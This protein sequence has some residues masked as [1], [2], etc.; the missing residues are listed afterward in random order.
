MAYDGVAE[1]KATVDRVIRIIVDPS[2]SQLGAQQTN[3]ALRSVRRE[4]RATNRE[5][6]RGG[7]RSRDQFRSVGNELRGVSTQVS[8]LRATVPALIG[9]LG[10]R[11][12]LTYADAWRSLTNRLRVV[13]ESTAELVAN[14]Q[15]VVRIALDTRQSVQAITQLYS[16]LTLVST[17]L[18]ASQ[19]EIALFTE[20]V[21]Q[22]LAVQGTGAQEARGALI[23]LSQAIGGTIVRAEEFNSINEAT[24]VL[25]QAVARGME[26]TGGSISALRREI[27]DGNVTS[28]EFFDSFLRGS[29]QIAEQFG[30]TE[31]T[32]SQGVENLGTG[33]TVLV[34]RVDEAVGATRILGSVLSGVGR[35]MGSF[36]DDTGDATDR[37]SEINAELR[38]LSVS[39]PASN[40]F[41]AG[42]APAI[43]FL[44]RRELIREQDIIQR[45]QINARPDRTREF[46]E[47]PGAT[48]REEESGLGLR[49]EQ[50]E[51]DAFRNLEQREKDEERLR[52]EKQR[53]IERQSRESIS[54]RAREARAVE[55]LARDEAVLQIRINN[56]IEEE[57]EERIRAQTARNREALDVGERRSL[58][59]REPDQILADD[60]A[61]LTDE[62]EA[63][64][65]AAEAL[66]EANP[67]TDE[68]LGDSIKARIADFEAFTEREDEFIQINRRLQ[69]S[70]RG[71]SEDFLADFIIAGAQGF[72]DLG[73]AAEQFGRR[74][75]RVL[76]QAI[77]EQ[78][79]LLA[80]Q[81][82]TGTAGTG[83]LINSALGSLQEGGNVAKGTVYN[84]GELGSELFVPHSFTESAAPAARASEVTVQ[85]APTQGEP[86]LLPRG[87]VPFL[88]PE[89]GVIIPN[90]RIA[91]TIER[92]T[93]VD[94]ASRDVVSR[95]TL[96]LHVIPDV[97][98]SLS[99]V[100][101]VEF[102]DIPDDIRRDVRRSVITDVRGVEPGDARRSVVT[103]K[104][105]RT[106]TEETEAH[107]RILSR[108]DT[109]K[110]ERETTDANIQRAETR[111]NDTVDVQDSTATTIREV[112]QGVFENIRQHR[113]ER[114][115]LS[116]RRSEE[117]KS[118]TDN[119]DIRR[120]DTLPVSQN[121]PTLLQVGMR[122]ILSTT[123]RL[124]STSDSTQFTRERIERSHARE[125]RE[126][127]TVTRA[128]DQESKDLVQRSRR[129]DVRSLHEELREDAQTVRRVHTE[130]A[131]GPRVAPEAL[132]PAGETTGGVRQNISHFTEMVNL[133]T[134]TQNF[135]REVRLSNVSSSRGLQ[136]NEARNDISETKRSDVE[137][138]QKLFKSSH[139]EIRNDVHRASSQRD[140]EEAQRI[141]STRSDAKEQ[142]DFV[143]HRRVVQIPELRQTDT[144][145]TA[146]G[147]L[148]APDGPR[149][150]V[151]PVDGRI[152]PNESLRPEERIR[153]ERIGSEALFSPAMPG[154][155]FGGPVS[156][157]SPV[158]VAEQGAELF[159]PNSASPAAA[160][161]SG[162]R[163]NVTVLTFTDL[164][165]F[166][167]EL[168]KSSADEIVISGTQNQ[169]ETL[170]RILN[171][172]G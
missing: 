20:R 165:S 70:L 101:S 59:V 67:F 45:E 23:Q 103:D 4:Q 99:T 76:A 9:V 135:L 162:E 10:I 120:E 113:T 125:A 108:K 26:R 13:S 116:L 24:P 115:E 50:T 155:Q 136:V 77:A 64:R 96:Q 161:G 109:E 19:Q 123:S 75:L 170:R 8:L 41:T 171:G 42:I 7:R 81:T 94:E 140:F 92:L 85:A 149:V 79:V 14:Q 146:R 88:A 130:E 80:I 60:V 151:P 150:F 97:S 38:E 2:G 107:E 160:A 119:R 18:G 3:A 145:E 110:L 89:S 152:V 138:I 72:D 137:D 11:E 6:A 51:E 143:E 163:P 71:A 33:F 57:E 141:S 93:P 78:L 142:R 63:A 27:V 91:E 144:V 36:A 44:R 55:R 54:V 156:A 21:G 37:L 66:G 124:E 168:V 16:R 46:D 105:K 65:A 30:R 62:F 132:R 158:R 131:K 134:D 100:E 5:L 98:R 172:G 111:R 47:L 25:L 31:T 104:L 82:V 15:E 157:G 159:V 122:G 166:R 86:L 118:I 58:D 17:E 32:I 56:E 169:A 164:E 121:Q 74:L 12:V 90:N 73:D 114:N 126:I 154:R 40:I 39:A 106:R 127:D 52:D 29:G 153:A 84:V 112:R 87:P 22:G 49:I 43:R 117:S 167:A 148:I 139:D 1:G 95:E 128:V 133:S 69:R 35:F 83:G 61:Q 129:E 48:R 147:I 53:D 102:A 28:E 68:V 34:G